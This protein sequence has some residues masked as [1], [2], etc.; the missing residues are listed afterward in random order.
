[1]WIYFIPAKYIVSFVV[2]P[3]TAALSR[4]KPASA[5]TSCDSGDD[6]ISDNKNVL[7]GTYFT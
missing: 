3:K 5:G 6:F 7:H 4:S 2:A 1:M